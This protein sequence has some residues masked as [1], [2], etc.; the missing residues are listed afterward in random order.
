[1]QD[2][3]GVWPHLRHP[4]EDVQYVSRDLIQTSEPRV[5]VETVLDTPES[6]QCGRHPESKE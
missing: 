2:S 3:T 1:M 5:R 6:D 4:K